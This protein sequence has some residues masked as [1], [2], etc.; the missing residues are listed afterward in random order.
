M[1]YVFPDYV[2]SRTSSRSTWGA[3]EIFAYD[4][5][6]NVWSVSSSLPVQLRY[7]SMVYIS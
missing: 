4:T 2:P 7:T 1:I 5:S 6:T 3:D